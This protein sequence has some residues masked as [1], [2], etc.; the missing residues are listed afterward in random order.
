[1]SLEI[2]F[3]YNKLNQNKNV[4]LVMG[5]ATGFKTALSFIFILKKVYLFLTRIE[6]FLKK[7][8]LKPEILEISGTLE[9]RIKK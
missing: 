5:G 3:Y 1:M 2:I 7:D 8:V 6:I 4:F 9:K